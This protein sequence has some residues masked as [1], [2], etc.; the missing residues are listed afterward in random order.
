MTLILVGWALM[1]LGYVR[2]DPIPLMLGLG[3]VVLGCIFPA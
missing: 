2:E 1:L 3:F